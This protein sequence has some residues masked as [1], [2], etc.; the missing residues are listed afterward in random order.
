MNETNSELT[1][2][3]K[4]STVFNSELVCSESK[5][6]CP[7]KIEKPSSLRTSLST[8]FSFWLSGVAVKQM[9]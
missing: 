7:L 3:F 6:G 4:A 2:M 5:S 9:Q 8:P 1:G